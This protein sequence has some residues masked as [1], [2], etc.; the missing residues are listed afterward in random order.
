MKDD[1]QYD[2]GFLFSAEDEAGLDTYAY[3]RG[4]LQYKLAGWRIWGSLLE[5]YEY[6]SVYEQID[7]QDN[8]AT[9][10]VRP[11]AYGVSRGSPDR[12]DQINM[13]PHH[14]VLVRRDNGWLIQ[15]DEWEDEMTPVL[16]C[17]T[18]F[19]KLTR[20]L[21]ERVKPFLDEDKARSEELRKDPQNAPPQST[22]PDAVS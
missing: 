19:D 5:R 9:V 15:R 2:L 12:T 7:V 3:E 4:R 10:V 6:A 16:P 11:R 20:E 18:D 1:V 14:L 13:E 17:G 21:P 22:T 8:L